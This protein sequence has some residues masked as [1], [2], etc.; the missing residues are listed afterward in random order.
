MATNNNASQIPLHF[1][2]TGAD[3]KVNQQWAFWF[4]NFQNN[5]PPPGSGYIIDGSAGTSGPTTIFQGIDL[6]KGASPLPGYIYFATDT[7]KIYIEQGGAWVLESPAYTG[8]VTKALHGTDLTLNT[9][10]FTPGTWGDQNNYPI[11][12]VDAKGRVTNVS[13][14]ET[15]GS[16]G[17]PGGPSSSVQFNNNGEFA[18][19]SFLSYDIVSATL[20]AR[21]INIIDQITFLNAPPTL[22]NLSP[23]TSPGDLLTKTG[24]NP[25]VHMRLPVGFD[26][27]VLT[28]DSSVTG[29]LAW[30]DGGGGGQPS[31]FEMLFDHG[32][33]SPKPLFIIDADRIIE[34]VTIILM[35]AFNATS[36]LQIGTAT[37]PNILFDV[38]DINTQA[39]GTYTTEP[40]TKFA[41][42]TQLILT[43]TPGATTQGNGLVSIN[44]QK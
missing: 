12:T 28:A 44:Y 24:G 20:T 25:N 29:G 33:A 19:D 39:T 8:D 9:V 16:G 34:S 3:G 26:G 27:Q 38:T 21:K 35:T 37:T 6:N 32:D 17:S 23:L 31:K 14:Q 36:S 22:N 41:A 40:A 5:L 15:G 10:N 4:Q 42:N 13:L 7:G 18:G 43:I 30:T 2:I 1:N 11:I